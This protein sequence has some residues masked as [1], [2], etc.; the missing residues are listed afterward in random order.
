MH[1]IVSV[2]SLS[3]LGGVLGWLL[4]LA[5]R[6]LKVEAGELISHDE[7]KKRIKTWHT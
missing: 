1:D 5:S 2:L 4:G 7:A 6:Y 3:L